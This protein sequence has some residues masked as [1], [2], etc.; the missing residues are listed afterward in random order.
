MQEL[1]EVVKTIKKAA[2]EHPRDHGV[3]RK[4]APLPAMAA[5]MMACIEEPQAQV[6]LSNA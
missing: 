2:D 5:T 6:Y 1:K 3:S 4:P